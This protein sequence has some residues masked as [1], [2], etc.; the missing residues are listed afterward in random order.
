MVAMPLTSKGEKIEAALKSEYGTKKGEQ[1]LYA[2]KNKGTFTGV[3]ADALADLRD[4]ADALRAQCD[5]LGQRMDA[6]RRGDSKAAGLRSDDWSDEA[7]K[8]ALEAR[9]AGYKPTS[10]PSS[11]GGHRAKIEGPGGSNPYLGA[12][13][14]KSAT[15]AQ[16]EAS[17]VMAGVK[18]GFHY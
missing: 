2:G 18:P 3:D 10:E 13:G 1:V 17:R 5:A 16:R 9:S 14:F 12:R 7:R 4:R 11:F 15:K 6:V 8:K